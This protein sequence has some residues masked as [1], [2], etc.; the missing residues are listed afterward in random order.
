VSFASIPSFNIQGFAGLS[1]SVVRL[2]LTSSTWVNPAGVTLKYGTP[3]INTRDLSQ[4]TGAGNPKVRI[5]LPSNTNS[6]ALD[7]SN[8]CKINTNLGTSVGCDPGDNQLGSLQLTTSA[9][10]TKVVDIAD[11]LGSTAEFRFYGARSSAPISHI[12]ISLSAVNE[13]GDA[14]TN[15]GSIVLTRIAFGTLA[16]VPEPSTLLLVLAG[17]VLVLVLQRRVRLS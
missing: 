15:V 16:E 14:I 2:Y 3:I 6:F 11:P 10:D 12:D 4:S 1:G 8:G 9:G 17:L 5:N 7:L 13:A